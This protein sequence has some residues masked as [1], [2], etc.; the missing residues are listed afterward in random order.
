MSRLP[1]TSLEITWGLPW[2]SSDVIGNLTSFDIGGFSCFGLAT[3]A[4][5]QQTNTYSGLDS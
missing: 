2:T 3:L 5:A 4:S 1:L